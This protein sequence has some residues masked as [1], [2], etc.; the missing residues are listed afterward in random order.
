MLLGR[1]KRNA[2]M[3]IDQLANPFKILLGEYKFT[4]LTIAGLKMNAHSVLNC[5]LKK[6]NP[7][8]SRGV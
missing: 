2:G 5:L 1:L 7:A 3:L 4:I 8:A 6:D